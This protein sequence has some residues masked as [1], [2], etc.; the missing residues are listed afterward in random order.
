[1]PIYINIDVFYV[2]NIGSCCKQ[3]F[4]SYSFPTVQIHPANHFSWPFIVSWAHHP[5]CRIFATNGYISAF[6]KSMVEG[7]V[8]STSPSTC[9]LMNCAAWY[10][11]LGEKNKGK[12][13]CEDV[14]ILRYAP[15]F[16]LRYWQEKSKPQIL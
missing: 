2:A 3:L 14:I 1:M 6:S 13:S 16:P 8:Y 10:G 15:C 9:L 7:F 12:I 4:A 5:W 11:A